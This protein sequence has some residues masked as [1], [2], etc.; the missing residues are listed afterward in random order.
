MST[1]EI[2]IEVEDITILNTAMKNLPITVR[3]TQ[4][5]KYGLLTN[6]GNQTDDPNSSI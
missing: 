1:G 6:N 5:N 3:D 2:E 4:V